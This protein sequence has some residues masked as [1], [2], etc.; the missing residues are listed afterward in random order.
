MLSLTSSY[1]LGIWVL[2]NFGFMESSVELTVWAKWK[3]LTV[4]STL[5]PLDNSIFHSKMCCCVK[6]CDHWSNNIFTECAGGSRSQWSAG[7]RPLIFAY[8]K[9]VALMEVK[10]C[11]WGNFFWPAF[12][13]FSV[14]L[15]VVLAELLP[16]RW[17]APYIQ[18][19][20][21][22]KKSYIFYVL[23]LSGFSSK[24]IN[25]CHS[26][27]GRFGVFEWASFFDWSRAQSIDQGSCVDL[28]SHL[29][30]SIPDFSAC[31]KNWMKYCWSVY[32]T[33]P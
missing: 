16:Q 28:R 13:D 25:I 17:D 18:S 15:T 31:Y 26:N 32:Q 9:T 22:G 27:I 21:R 2:G 11:F 8:L 23:L 33:E 3:L 24:C 14:D 20:L 10:C 1:T 7:C 12:S 30:E 6:H 29:S 5:R 19:L 4:F